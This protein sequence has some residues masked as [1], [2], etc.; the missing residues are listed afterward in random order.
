MYF[1][2]LK[3]IP[4]LYTIKENDLTLEIDITTIDIDI[5][6]NEI[7]IIYLVNDSKNKYK[8]YLTWKN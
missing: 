4:S 3:T 7:K 1:N 8:Y 6:D 5:T 2:Y